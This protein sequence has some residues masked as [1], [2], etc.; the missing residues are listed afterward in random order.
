MRQSSG[1]P[2]RGMG[3]EDAPRQRSAADEP[4]HEA[5]TTRARS[6]L[7]LATGVALTLAYFLA[8]RL[9][10]RQVGDL[11][12]RRWRLRDRHARRCAAVNGPDS[13]WAWLLLAAGVGADIGDDLNSIGPLRPARR[14]IL[15]VVHRRR[16][17]GHVSAADRRPGDTGVAALGRPRSLDD[18]RHL[19]HHYRAGTGVVGL[20]PR[21]YFRDGG[22]SMLDP[23]HLDRHP[24]GDF[25]VLATAVRLVVGGGRRPTAFWLLG[26][27]IVHADERRRRVRLPQLVEHVLRAHWHRHRLDRLLRLIG[28][29][30][31]PSLD[32]RTVDAVA[33]PGP[34]STSRLV[35]I[36]SA[37]LLARRCCSSRRRGEVTDATA[38]AFD[39]AV[40]V[41]LV[42]VRIVGLVRSAAEFGAKPAS[43]RWSTSRRTPSSSS[44]VMPASSST[45]PPRRCCSVAAQRNCRERSSPNCSVIP[46]SSA[47]G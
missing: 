6:S 36:G 29:R 9:S 40:L 27:G 18:H 35:V 8:P 20:A 23:P 47:C 37:V 2:W 30:G 15:S 13:R 5:V 41:A 25:V 44:T 38:I 3:S 39:S 24:V 43:G 45:L 17:R 26:G 1:V 7:F 28:R 10:C 21:S 31:P 33:S 16:L 32:G 12:D 22:M 34:I 46:T 4:A 11:A 19:H 42:M 14:A